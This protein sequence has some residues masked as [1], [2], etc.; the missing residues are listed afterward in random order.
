MAP[1]LRHI[2]LP[3]IAPILFFG[4]AATPVDVLSCKTRGL[5]AVIIA[6][7]SVLGG[8]ASAIMALKGRL[9]GHRLRTGGSKALVLAIR[10]IGLILLA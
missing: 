7:A 3:A 4:V 9:R 1:F 8:L 6:F 10:A 5:L 2:A